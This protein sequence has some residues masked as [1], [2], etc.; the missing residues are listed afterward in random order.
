LRQVLTAALGPKEH[1]LVYEGAVHTT[2]SA[3]QSLVFRNI[4][5]HA[6]AANNAQ[7][8]FEPLFPLAAG[9]DVAKLGKAVTLEDVAISNWYV[10]AA[11]AGSLMTFLQGNIW[12][13]CFYH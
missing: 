2:S 12:R 4:V 7:L 9:S 6:T 1:E 3:V 5:P 11:R 10:V 8:F 13:F